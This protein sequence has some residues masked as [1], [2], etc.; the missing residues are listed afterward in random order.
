MWLILLVIVTGMLGPRINGLFLISIRH[1]RI[2]LV[3]GRIPPS[4]LAAF[5]DILRVA[6]IARGTVRAVRGPWHTHLVIRGIDDG[7]AQRLGNVFGIH[8]LHELRAAPPLADGNF[9]QLLGWTWLAW[10]LLRR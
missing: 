9:G 1:E 3:R 4:L 2:L 10:F 6:H 8:P 7:T 5:A